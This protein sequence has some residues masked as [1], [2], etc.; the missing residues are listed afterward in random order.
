MS[1]LEVDVRFFD[2]FIFQFRNYKF[3]IALIGQVV[4][5]LLII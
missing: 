2:L 3:S 5:E 4:Y 1:G